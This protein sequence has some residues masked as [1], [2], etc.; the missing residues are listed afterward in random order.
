MNET[1]SW[2]INPIDSYS[3]NESGIGVL[4]REFLS[5]SIPKSRSDLMIEI[6]GYATKPTEAIDQSISYLERHYIAL[7]DNYSSNRK[8]LRSSELTLD[9]QFVPQAGGL[10]E[11]LFWAFLEDEKEGITWRHAYAI[12]TGD[13]TG[14]ISKAASSNLQDL[15]SIDFIR[16]V[17]NGLFVRNSKIGTS[18]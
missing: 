7:P 4:V 17:Q 16:E 6:Y 14:E 11:N 8:L 12:A 9:Q 2:S 13:A 5:T 3:R 1:L 18:R 10:Y 15:Y